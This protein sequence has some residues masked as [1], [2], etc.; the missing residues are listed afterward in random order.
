MRF[1]MLT[2]WP[3]NGGAL[4][5]PAGT[6]LEANLANPDFRLNGVKLPEQMPL[7]AIALDQDAYDAMCRWHGGQEHRF[8]Y[9]PGIVP[10][11]AR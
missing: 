5:V 11:R 3:V 6:T 4:I 7:T 1:Q 2:D 9:G 10:Q 8:H